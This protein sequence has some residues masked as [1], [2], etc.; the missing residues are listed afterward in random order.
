[1]KSP[2]SIL[3]HLLILF[4]VVVAT[5]AQN[6]RVDRR[7]LEELQVETGLEIVSH[8]TPNIRMVQDGT[9][10]F[11]AIAWKVTANEAAFAVHDEGGRQQG[12]A[13]FLLRPGAPSKS[14]Y[15]TRDGDVNINYGEPKPKKDSTNTPKKPQ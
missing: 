5:T 7:S 3:A 9:G 6:L 10:N 1:M 12:H 11:D 14:L 15:I 4:T 8:D 13:P 2:S